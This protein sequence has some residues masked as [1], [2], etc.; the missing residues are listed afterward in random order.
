MLHQ[1][2]LITNVRAGTWKILSG[3]NAHSYDRC[4]GHQ[5]MWGLWT[6]E[7]CVKS[8]KYTH[9]CKYMCMYTQRESQRLSVRAP[10]THGTST[11][12]TAQRFLL[13]SWSIDFTIQIVVLHDELNKF[14]NTAKRTSCVCVYV[15]SL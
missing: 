8:S 4:S 2:D 1:R 13:V 12:V 3:D 10:G 14:K 7:M 6:G 15:Q 9:T 5:G 11:E